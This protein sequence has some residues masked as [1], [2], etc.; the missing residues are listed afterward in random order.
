M[1]VYRT[2]PRPDHIIFDNNCHL[3]KIVKNN[4][5]FDGI[6]LSV[7]VFHFKAKHSTADKFCQENCNPRAFPELIRDDGGWFFNSSIAEQTNVWLGGYHSICRELHV[8]KYNF[9]LDEMIIRRNRITLEALEK[10]G[11]QPMYWI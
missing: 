1:R 10:S 3:A 11:Q 5:F 8:F 2:I 4:P 6:G 7:D 9:F